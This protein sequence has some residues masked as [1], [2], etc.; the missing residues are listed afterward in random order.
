MLK[1]RT[2]EHEAP[3]SGFS[4]MTE[5]RKDSPHPISHLLEQIYTR[6]NKEISPQHS[7]LLVFLTDFPS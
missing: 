6:Q 5:V 7:C 3:T 2:L 1:I 4:A